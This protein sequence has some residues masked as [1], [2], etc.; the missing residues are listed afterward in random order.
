MGRTEVVDHEGKC[1]GT[2]S[3]RNCKEIKNEALF[4]D[5]KRRRST[6]TYLLHHQGD[7]NQLDLAVV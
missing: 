1:Y 4:G 6:G 7:K 2:E 5:K 3:G